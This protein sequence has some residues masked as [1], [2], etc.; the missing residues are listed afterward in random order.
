MLRSS[1]SDQSIHVFLL[2]PVCHNIY[3]KYPSKTTK[4]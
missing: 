2:R 1:V 4:Y 3:D